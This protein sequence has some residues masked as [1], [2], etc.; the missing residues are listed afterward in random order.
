M[1]TVILSVNCPSDH[2]KDS[3]V[4]KKLSS[5]ASRQIGKPE[6]YVMTQVLSGQV[7]TMG[8]SA[9]PCSFVRV[10]S[11]GGLNQGTNSNIS[12]D[13]AAL[14]GAE[15]GVPANRCYIEFV[16]VTERCMFGW[17]GGTF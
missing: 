13:I 8:G 11:I 4:A 12:A 16:D 17:N 9:D 2:V 10:V 14:V 6:Q 3:D 5:I 15:Y 7:M 1:P